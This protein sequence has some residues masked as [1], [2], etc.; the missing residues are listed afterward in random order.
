MVHT[1]SI[2]WI[3]SR[4]SKWLPTFWDTWEGG[5]GG[6]SKPTT[7]WTS[8]IELY[9]EIALIQDKRCHNNIFIFQ[10]TKYHKRV[11]INNFLSQISKINHWFNISVSTGMNDIWRQ[12]VWVVPILALIQTFFLNWKAFGPSFAIPLIPMH[13]LSLTAAD[14]EEMEFLIS[15]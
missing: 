7:S 9:F 3:E 8:S 13:D 5:W 14:A 2:F 1:R 10:D 15:L 11:M 6:T 4:I 12:S